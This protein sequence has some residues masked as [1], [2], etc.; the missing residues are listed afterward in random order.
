MRP[1]TCKTQQ[2]ILIL[3]TPSPGAYPLASYFLKLANMAATPT[4]RIIVDHKDIM[5]LRG[6]SRTTAS[7]YLTTLRATLQLK[8]RQAITVYDIAKDMRLQLDQLLDCLGLPY[9]NK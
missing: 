9:Q 5:K 4:S 8:A 7:N 6:C 3:C 2:K 1:R